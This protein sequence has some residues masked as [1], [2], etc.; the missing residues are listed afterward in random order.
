MTY[1]LYSSDISD[2]I[3]EG[4]YGAEAPLIGSSDHPSGYLPDPGLVDA[5]NVALLLGKPMLLTGDPGTGKTQLAYS[6]A[7]QL[8]S[9]RLINVSS[10]AVEK[11]ETKS[12]SQ[13]MDLFYTFDTLRRFHA[14]QSG[15]STKNVDYITYNALGTAILSALPYEA[16]ADVVRSDFIFTRP[17]RTTVLIDEIDKA[18][19]DFPN[20]LLNE[21]EEMYFRVP[22]LGNLSVGGI[23]LISEDM[24]PILFITSNS[25][26]NLPDP[27]LRR[28]IYY[29]IPFPGPDRLKAILLSR[30]PRLG[31]LQGRLLA[32]ATALFVRLQSENLRR[33]VSPAELIHWLSFMLRRGALHDRPLAE[34]EEQA[35]AGVGALAKDPSDQDQIQN[36]LRDFLRKR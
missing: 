34:A 16:I 5:V 27:F 26:K 6:V 8:A 22:E 23:K 11:F 19:R 20:D 4:G 25:E 14:A 7:W 33:K 21:I 32:D 24:R 36:T 31:S 3:S 2:I 9:R 18:S 29:H 35:L 28:C 13:S 30:L 1:P 10:A 17:K 15:G 12:T